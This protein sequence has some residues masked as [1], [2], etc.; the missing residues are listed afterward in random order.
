[1][2]EYKKLFSICI[3]TLL[4]NGLAD[5][6]AALLQTIFLSWLAADWA[7]PHKQAEKKTI[8]SVVFFRNMAGLIFSNLN[9]LF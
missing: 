4:A 9:F 3:P 7:R 6:T 8:S 2:N 1:M 5:T